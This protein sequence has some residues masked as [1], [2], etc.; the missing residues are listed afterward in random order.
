[1]YLKGVNRKKSETFNPIGPELREQRT[2][3][4]SK[5]MGNIFSTEDNQAYQLKECLFQSIEC[6]GIEMT[7][8][9]IV[10]AISNG[11]GHDIITQIQAIYYA[12]VNRRDPLFIG[13]LELVM[14]KEVA[15]AIV[16][17]KPKSKNTIPA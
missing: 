15:L 3:E 7:L 10:K 11:I 8:E 6:A 14:P 13:G 1:M 12:N 4:V 9:N 16:N 2:D 17:Y 5:Y